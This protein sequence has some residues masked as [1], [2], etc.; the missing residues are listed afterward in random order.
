M[1]DPLIL[2]I[3]DDRPAAMEIRGALMQIGYRVPDQVYSGTESAAKAAE[4]KPDLIIANISSR[5]EAGGINAVRQIQ[6]RIDVPVIYLTADSSPEIFRRAIETNPLAYL[7]KPVSSDQLRTAVEK[8]LQKGGLERKLRES[9]ERYRTLFEK[10]PEPIVI[11]ST[12][13]FVLNVNQAY[14]EFTGHTKEETLGVAF[15]RLPILLQKHMPEYLEIY[16]NMMRGNKLHLMEIPVIRKNGTEMYVEIFISSIVKEGETTAFQIIARDVTEQKKLE[17]NLQKANELLEHRVRERTKKLRNE[18]EERKKAELQL[19]EGEEVARALI[20]SPSEPVFLASA[21]GTVIDLNSELE[22]R[23]GLAKSEIIGRSMFDFLSKRT[24]ARYREKMEAVAVS[25]KAIRFENQLG[26][27]WYDTIMY[28]VPDYRGLVAKVAVFSH[29]ITETR[30]LQKDIMK[31]SEL[32]RNRI[33]QELH[34]GL[35]QKLTGIA[36]LAEALKRTMK[37]KKYPEVS[38]VEEI[39]TNIAESIEQARKISS[40]LWTTR[41]E[42]YDAGRALQELAD[43]TENLFSIT[44]KLDSHI[45]N[46]VY[47]STVVINLYFIARESINN[48]IR[49]GRADR[50]DL[51][52]KDDRDSLYLEVTDNGIGAA[53]SF[54]EG[55]GIGLRIMQ[56]RAGIIG[57]TCAF[58]NAGQGFTVRVTIRKEFIDTYL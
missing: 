6:E 51:R 54:R 53:A 14:E 2:I 40:G 46:P 26:D 1:S 23:L 35:G 12:D 22:K 45:S 4:L 39:T 24:A 13:G 42:S 33:G 52:M 36:F 15:T 57:G 49:H 47:N 5:G 43:D 19:R 32:E 38:D 21:D 41:L 27:S 31:I 20:D 8:A 56:Y 44:C 58:E 28:P 10:S 9:E 37:E 50:I 29:D 30:R 48:A 17:Q 11:F 7:V 3:G 16:R 18:I 34:D 55:S 25:G